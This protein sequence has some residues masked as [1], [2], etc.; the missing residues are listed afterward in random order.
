MS[1]GNIDELIDR[2]YNDAE[3]RAALR[4]DPEGTL[5]RSGIELSD[6]VR[7]ALRGLDPTQPTDAQLEERISK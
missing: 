5:A 1:S 4:A 7:E 3:F 6:E 2:W